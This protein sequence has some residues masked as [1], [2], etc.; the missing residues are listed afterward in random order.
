MT[1]ASSVHEMNT[2]AGVGGRDNPSPHCAA[3]EWPI[4]PTA[5][6]GFRLIPGGFFTRN[7]ALDV[8]R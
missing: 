2:R 7:P 8:P 6:V 3:D 1:G 5:H 4:M